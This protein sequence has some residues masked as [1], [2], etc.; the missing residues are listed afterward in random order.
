LAERI[1]DARPD[2]EET[3]L[4]QTLRPRRLTEFAGQKKVVEQLRIAIAAAQQRHEPI[5]HILLYGPPGLGKTT[6]VLVLAQE[7]GVNARITS[8]PAIERPG[9]LAALLTNL[10][11]G[12]VL[13]IDEIHRLHH[14]VEEVLYPA[15]EDFALDLVIGRGPG[16]RSVRLKLPAFTLVGATTRYSMISAPL[17]DRFT[18]THRLDF[19]TPDELTI[20]LRRDA[21]ILGIEAEPSALAE[22]ATRSRGTVRIAI[23][24]LKRARDY[25]QVNAGGAVTTAIV[26]ACLD[27]L[28]VDDAGLDPM[29]RALLE[30]LIEKFDGR[31]VGLET[32]AAAISEEP[33]TVQQVYEP[34]LLQ[35]GFLERTPR[36]RKATRLA[37]A[38]LGMVEPEAE[39]VIQQGRLL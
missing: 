22:L 8:G 33:D 2:D 16:A 17:R 24:L 26:E 18:L 9:D 30:A 25:A 10:G 21:R 20:I 39:P 15:M 11:L 37:Y 23:R 19:Y 35:L 5:D 36:G 32:L 34:Y 1:A 29:D 27:Q 31:A 4:E 38:H 13:F 7:M 12:D 28:E 14:S 6:L 3:A